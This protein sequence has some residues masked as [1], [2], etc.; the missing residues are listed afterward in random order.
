MSLGRVNDPAGGH[1]HRQIK[2]RRRR[3]HHDCPDEVAAHSASCP[4]DLLT[5]LGGSGEWQ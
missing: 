4:V 5:N 3:D 1:R 2:Q